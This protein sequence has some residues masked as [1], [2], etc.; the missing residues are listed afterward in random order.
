MAAERTNYRSR[1]CHSATGIIYLCHVTHHLLYSVTK[2]L[3]SLQCA[4]ALYTPD[5]QLYLLHPQIYIFWKSP[6]IRFASCMSLGMIV[7]LLA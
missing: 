2:T 4:Q 1:T 3:Q 6:L 7:T 5:K